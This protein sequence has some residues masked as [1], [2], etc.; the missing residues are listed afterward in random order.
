MR[1]PSFA[2]LA[3]IVTLVLGSPG[4]AGAAATGQFSLSGSSVHIYNIVGQ[5]EVVAGSGKSVLIDLSPQG[6]DAAQLGTKTWGAG[7]TYFVVEYP[8]DNI[9]Y[10]RMHSNS[11]TG[12]TVAK[13]GTFG[14]KKGHHDNWFGGGG[15][16]V[17]VGGG[18]GLEAWCDMKISVPKGQDVSVHLGVGVARVTN[19]DGTLLVKCESADVT[20]TGTRGSLTLDTG[21]G[22]LSVTNAEGILSFDTGSGSVEGTN[23]RGTKILADTGSGEVSF[24]GVTG[25]TL[26]VDTGSGSVELTGISCPRVLVDTGSGDVRVRMVGAVDDMNVDTGS[27]TVTIEAPATL[28]A[29]LHFE[30]GSGDVDTDFPLKVLHRDDDSLTATIGDGHGRIAVD[31][32]SGSVRLRRI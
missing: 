25:Q 14:D 30:T 7:G 9:R 2:T 4:H 3:L 29:T 5:V 11:W 32:G 6:K 13:D 24:D 26:S 20:T 10:T 27:G 12:F 15:R 16:K 1:R 31:T 8:S 18:S 22:N 21:S 17:K 28:G 19:V 23:L